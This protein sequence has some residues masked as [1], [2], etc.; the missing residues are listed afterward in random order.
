MLTCAYGLT[1]NNITIMR[2]SI[3]NVSVFALSAFA[4]LMMAS[5]HQS[6]QEK[7]DKF[8][9]SLGEENIILAEV[10]DSTAQK[11]FYHNTTSL[12]DD[13]G[14]IKDYELSIYDV[15]TQ[16]TTVLKLDGV[17]EILS[18]KQYATRL[19]FSG[20]GDK[21]VIFGGDVSII[22]RIGYL[23]YYDLTDDSIHYVKK[24][25]FHGEGAA[26][27]KS[28]MDVTFG[29]KEILV[30]LH[31]MYSDLTQNIDYTIF[32]NLP[33]FEYQRIVEKMENEYDFI[34]WNKLEKAVSEEFSRRMA[35]INSKKII[36]IEFDL[37]GLSMS[38]FQMNGVCGNHINSSWGGWLI[39]DKIRVPSGKQWICKD[40]IEENVNDCYLEIG[41]NSSR[42]DIRKGLV[43]A[44]DDYFILN[45]KAL[46]DKHCKIHIEFEEKPF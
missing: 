8:K 10:I 26:E 33:D 6:Y 40:Y 2:H 15:E 23:F 11:I 36:H 35:E 41:G 13:K 5:C 20:I 31:V 18:A 39:T 1:N 3:M 7:A 25:G 12:Q 4:I 27:R 43:I 34:K 17:K 22:H 9:Q 46:D 38:N 14:N 24:E 32:P 37:H 45:L 19:F 21:E 42:V 44:D 30:T 29:E 16:K 28:D